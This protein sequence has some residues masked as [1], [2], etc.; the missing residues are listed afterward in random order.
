MALDLEPLQVDR[1]VTYLRLLVKWNRVYNLSGIQDAAAMIALHILDS[2]SAHTYIMGPRVLDVGSGAGLPGIPLAIAKPD[3]DVVLL[4]ANAKKTRF[5][6][7][8]ALELKIRNV[9]VELARI[10][11]YRPRIGFDTVVCRA[12]ASL[13]KFVAAASHT[14]ASGGRLLAMKGALSAD[15]RQTIASLGERVR[16]DKLTVPGIGAERQLVEISK[17]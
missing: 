2:L 5:I 8:A 6:Q 13:S 7:Q 1:L 16:I 3:L 4:D 10:E 17:A 9:R 11:D 12:F 14:C 15:E